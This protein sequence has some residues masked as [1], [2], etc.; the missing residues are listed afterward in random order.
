MVRKNPLWKRIPREIWGEKYKYLSLFIFLT[1]TISITSGFLVSVNS[2]ETKFHKNLLFNKIEDGHFVTESKIGSNLIN[3]LESDELE[4]YE[5][6]YYD[7]DI[8]NGSTLRV[9]ANREDINTP[10]LMKGNLPV[11]EDEIALDRLYCKNNSLKIGDY[12]NIDGNEFKITGYVALPD[13]GALFKNNSDMMLDA[14]SFG[15]GLVNEESLQKFGYDTIK[16]C[17]A[18]RYNI[19]DLSKEEKNDITEDMMDTLIQTTKLNDF[20]RKVNNQAI[21]FPAFD[22]G[23][24]RPMTITM[25]YIFVIGL[26]F[27]FAI[28]VNSTIMQEAEVI[29]VLRA[30]GYSIMELVIHYM[31]PPIVVTT[32]AAVGGN[33]LGYTYMKDVNANQYM[34]SYS[35]SRF[36]LLFNSEAFIITTVYPI[37]I[38]AIVI[39]SVIYSTLKISPLKLLKADFTKSNKRRLK[40]QLSKFSFITKFRIRVILQNFSTYIAVFFGILFATVLLLFSMFMM[41][42]VEHFKDIVYDSN[43]A[44]YQYILTNPI[45]TNNITAEK[46]AVSSLDTDRGEEIMIYGIDDESEYFLPNLPSSNKKGLV[47]ASEPLL[48][49]Y[50]YKVGQ[51]ITLKE[52]LEDEYYDFQIYESVNYSATLSIFMPI[53]TFNDIFD[54]SDNYFN[55]YF[56]KTEITDI[57]D[58]FIASVITIEDLV[59]ISKQMDSSMGK[60]FEFMKVFFAIMYIL[61]LYLL[62]KMVIDKNRNSISMIKIL[63]FTDKEISNLYNVTTAIVVL[64]SLLV[65]IP[66]S[67]K[68]IRKMYF[69][70][71]GDIKGWMI[72]YLPQSILVKLFVIGVLV[73][74][75]VH[76]LQMR[77]IKKINMAVAL[78]NMN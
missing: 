65:V 33:I 55:G 49:K 3:K 64:V 63:G 4:I 68:I 14:I 45:S 22:F 2:L 32:L 16:Y 36:E 72:Y 66:I 18:W 54:N 37:I 28:T 57:D 7:F 17:Y 59:S 62:S 70:M 15:V 42:V 19:R 1:L 26:A 35:L 61:M 44:N 43:L 50:G 71:F 5:L 40:I 6:F 21:N 48:E 27:I 51:I 24:D 20:V 30:S 53:D 11:E 13:Y 75:V 77:K 52:K 12:I 67:E 31:M 9:Y 69:S 39:F 74:T 41:P 60:I 34:N 25:L 58:R 47:I 38:I 76:F 8:D 29:G 46:Y 73:Y 10:D 78:K 23:K 56:S